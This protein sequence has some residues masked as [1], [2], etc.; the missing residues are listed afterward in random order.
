MSAGAALPLRCPS[1]TWGM[2]DATGTLTVRCRGKFCRTSEGNTVEHVF[3]LDSG[4]FETRSVVTA[5]GS[6]QRED[7][8][9]G[10]R[11]A[12]IQS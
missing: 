9:H 5:N 10:L 4:S 2:A 6:L 7:E 8:G 1:E 11:H 3:D 12:T